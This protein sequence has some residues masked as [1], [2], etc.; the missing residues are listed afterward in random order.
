MS[1]SR[2]FERRHAVQH[3]VAVVVGSLHPARLGHSEIVTLVG[4]EPSPTL[5]RAG[6]VIVRGANQIA[7]V[8]FVN[9]FQHQPAREDGNI[10]GMWLNSSEHLPA[11]GL[12][13]RA[14]FESPWRQTALRPSWRRHR[15]WLVRPGNAP[16]KL[17]A[18]HRITFS[19]ILT[20]PVG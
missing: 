14:R 8:P 20:L 6:M 1:R 15:K 11:C 13:E 9:Q 4:Q 7:G 19:G 2:K 12:P 16:D 18:L 5:P 3:M 10:V 17:V